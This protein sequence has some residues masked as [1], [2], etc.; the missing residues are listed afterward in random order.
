[1]ST[2]RP[3]PELQSLQRL[4]Q[5]LLT[6]EDVEPLAEH[7]ERCGRCVE[8]ILG[9]KQD[10]TLVDAVR[11]RRSVAEGSDRPIVE[12]L[13]QKLRR[14]PAEVAASSQHA[15]PA[16]SGDSVATPSDARAEPIRH[17]TTLPT[18]EAACELYDFLAPPERPD[19]LGWL[20]PYRVLKVLGAGGMG[21]V[22]LA[23]DPQLERQVALKV[24]KPVL[25][26]SE[27]ARKRFLQEAKATAAVENDHIVTIHQVSEDRG[28]P[29]I[30]MQVLHG[31]TLEDCLRRIESARR[32]GDVSS[33]M[34]LSEVLRI[35]REI[36]NGLAAAHGR[37]LMHRDVKPANI[38]LEERQG[39]R[40]AAVGSSVKNI[41]HDPN[42]SPPIANPLLPRVKIVDFG[43][44][45]AVSVRSSNLTQQGVI[46]GTPA[47]MAPEQANGE[48]PDQRCDLF[49]LGCVLYRMT[50]GEVPF[51]GS[52][53]LDTL[54]AVI[55]H[56]PKP[57]RELKPDV[58]Q[59]LSDLVM[60]LLAKNAADRPQSAHSVITAIESIERSLA[61]SKILALSP[62]GDDSPRGNVI[63]TSSPLAPVATNNSLLG[64]ESRG[65][66]SPIRPHA[67]A[68]PG[69]HAIT[70]NCSGCGKRLKVKPELDGKQMKCPG[71][72][73]LVRIAQPSASPSVAAEKWLVRTAHSATSPA[74]EPIHA[75]ER[76]GAG[77]EPRGA[78]GEPPSVA[79]LTAT[80][81]ARSRRPPPAAAQTARS[82]S[83]GVRKF[84]QKWPA[85]TAA[86][87]F[88][89][90]GLFFAPQ[91]I[92]I[93]TNKG[94]LVIKTDDPNVEVTVKE[95]GEAVIFDRT[96]ERRINLKAGDYE[97]DVVEAPGGVHLFTK[98]F[99]LTRGGKRIV[100]VRLELDAV[101]AGAESA[102]RQTDTS[103][104]TAEAS[105]IP[106]QPPAVDRRATTVDGKWRI[107]GTELVQESPDAAVASIAFGDPAWTDYEFS[108]EI[109]RTGGA[110]YC[111]VLY[112]ATD[113]DNWFDYAI[114]PE[115]PTVHHLRININGLQ[116]YRKRQ[117]NPQVNIDEWHT[118][119]VI[120]RGSKINCYCDAKEIFRD[121]DPRH[122]RGKVALATL[123]AAFRFR[124][125]AVNDLAGNV[126]FQGPPELPAPAEQ[127]G[128]ANVQATKPDPAPAVGTR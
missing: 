84:A 121:D 110:G 64:A 79:A 13:I 61:Q 99:S 100:D 108:A 59:A 73:Q 88:L 18:Q 7:L 81:G 43:L 60:N 8:T 127:D 78:S 70:F 74:Q 104:K 45:R 1:M 118:V 89:G 98:Q 23:E 41:E 34:P 20:G 106:R 47:Y 16:P 112:R 53:P 10:D 4:A 31:E 49:S 19:E 39:S 48:A 94:E 55:D 58:P 25:A 91:V 116:D 124:K 90:V 97:I 40:E 69:I 2:D 17:A 44:A 83:V 46:I 128:E 66:G 29:F 5:G 103:P 22:F 126:M 92:R 120:V 9:L 33:E 125:I 77:V 101:V 107:E 115:T 105:K 114:R 11:T 12:A 54:L 123:H 117:V 65:D 3:C 14:L 82:R 15:T 122:P 71:C 75:R 30:A 86:V 36:A 38:W 63:L 27:S 72:G 24:M 87:L 109:K 6:P 56:T 42:S 111:I 93:V 68:A 95:N 96:Q 67:T 80:G 57:P 50:A 119:S 62:A 21:V 35:G 26:V 102:K 113:K 28:V 76:R 32:A 85:V 52:T 51:K 37:H